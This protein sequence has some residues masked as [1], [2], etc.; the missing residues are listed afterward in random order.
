MLHRKPWMSFNGKHVRRRLAFAAST[1]AS[2]LRLDEFRSSGENAAAS[3]F[4]GRVMSWAVTRCSVIENRCRHVRRYDSWSR[5]RGVD[6]G[7]APFF[8]VSRASGVIWD[9]GSETAT[10]G[11]Q[12]NALP[13]RHSGTSR[14]QTTRCCSQCLSQN[15]H[16]RPNGH[17]SFGILNKEPLF[18]HI[19]PGIYHPNYLIIMPSNVAACRTSD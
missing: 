10:Q 7:Y 3:P 2:V 12:L 14:P 17:R 18:L 5:F 1:G 11:K 19:L 16:M 15:G 6:D 13:T 8:V 9:G 4:A